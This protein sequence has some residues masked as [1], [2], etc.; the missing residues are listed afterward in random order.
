MTPHSTP[1][2]TKRGAFAILFFFF[3]SSAGAD[4][5]EKEKRK[6]EK[7][8]GAVTAGGRFFFVF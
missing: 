6:K 3:L 2:H 5:D 8:E 4:A 7:L 1:T